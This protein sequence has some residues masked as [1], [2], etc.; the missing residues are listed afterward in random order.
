[1]FDR[2]PA[3]PHRRSPTPPSAPAGAHTPN[4]LSRLHVQGEAATPQGAPSAAASPGPASAG[5]ARRARALFTAPRDEAPGSARGAMSPAS[6]F[7]RQQSLGLASP[8]AAARKG[9]NCK[10]SRCLKLYCECFSSGRYCLATCNCV[11]CQNNRANETRRQQ[12][13]ESIL[14]RNPN[15]FRPKIAGT[16]DGGDAVRHNKGCNCRKSGCL[17]KYCE[18]FQAGIYCSENCKCSDC[19][20][21]EGSGALAAVRAQDPAGVPGTPPAKRARGGGLSPADSGPGT[22]TRGG[23]SPL[24]SLRRAS[25]Q[26]EGAE[27]GVAPRAASQAAR[28]ALSAR[29]REGGLAEVAE[30]LAG[31]A[32]GSLREHRRKVQER[33]EEGRKSR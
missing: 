10:N 7:R 8:G 26:A 29:L 6:P 32:L 23:P 9:C 19:K 33:E 25:S 30:R 17:K 24:A 14:E 20:N 3:Q 12:A 28:A 4:R 1:L 13:V 27:V 11:S 16:P 22:P 31:A 15:A 5:G 21:F 2:P 18:C